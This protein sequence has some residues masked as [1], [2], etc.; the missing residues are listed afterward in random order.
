[1]ESTLE[2]ELAM[3]KIIQTDY[4][5]LDSYYLLNESNVVDVSVARRLDALKEVIRTFQPKLRSICSDLDEIIDLLNDN[6][7][8][9]E[10]PVQPRLMNILQ[11][12][13]TVGEYGSITGKRINSLASSWSLVPST[14]KWTDD[15]LLKEAYDLISEFIEREFS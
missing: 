3:Q 7:G 14:E 9:N 1:M 6:D 8:L 10:N 11:T 2:L 13:K 12:L 5:L 15:N 4:S